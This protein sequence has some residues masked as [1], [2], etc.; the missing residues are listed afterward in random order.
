M[1]TNSELDT[2]RKNEKEL[3]VQFEGVLDVCYS[4]A[5]TMK[6]MIN[7]LV[8]SFKESYIL[9]AKGEEP[10]FKKLTH[11]F[12]ELIDTFITG[13]DIQPVYNLNSKIKAMISKIILMVED[14]ELIDLDCL[15]PLYIKCLRMVKS[16]Q[17]KNDDFI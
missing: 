17:Q 3:E 10:N 9:L 13:K 5:T 8:E 7:S 14:L 1:A 16:N 6:T 12:S 11:D 15:D 4:L 2:I